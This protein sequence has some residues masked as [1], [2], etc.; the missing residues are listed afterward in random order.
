MR[1]LKRNTQQIFYALYEDKT[2]IYDEYG[3]ETGEYELNY[4]TPVSLQVNISV[5]KGISL[6]QQF[7]Q[8]EDYDKVIITDDI[9]C[10]IDENSILWIDNLDIDEPYDYIV[11]RVAKSLNYI[12][13]AVKKVIVNASD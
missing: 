13:Y 12:S 9:T 8:I 7:G 2:P 5:A 6:I 10:P 1:L 4:S 3:N 11:K